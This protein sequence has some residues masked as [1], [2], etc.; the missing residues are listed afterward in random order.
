MRQFHNIIVSN[1][2]SPTSAILENSTCVYGS[3][4]APSVIE[5]PV[6]SLSKNCRHAHPVVAEDRR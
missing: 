2:D 1:G 3:T 5:G 6:L 4:P